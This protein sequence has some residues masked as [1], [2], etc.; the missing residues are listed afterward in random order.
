MITHRKSVPPV[1]RLVVNTEFILAADPRAYIHNELV[2]TYR[3]SVM[4]IYE[5]NR[6]V[7]EEVQVGTI[8]I[9]ILRFGVALN[10]G[11]DPAELANEI[12][13]DVSMIYEALQEDL[14]SMSD[15]L[16]QDYLMISH[17]SFEEPYRGSPIE[18]NTIR[19]ALIGLSSGVSRAF[20]PLSVINPDIKPTD[21]K[22]MNS[23]ALHFDK[24]GFKP[25]KLGS[26][27]LWLDLELRSFWNA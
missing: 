20:L 3:M 4:A 21:F 8:Q 23:T 1:I 27:T 5:C 24:I 6:S 18:L 26:N 10:L 15:G 17:L 13:N 22:E 9:K 25:L 16:H 7:F 11:Y 12:S 19:T 2:R 14:G